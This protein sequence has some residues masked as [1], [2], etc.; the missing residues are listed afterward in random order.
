MAKRQDPIERFW[1]QCAYTDSTQDCWEW[2]GGHDSGGYGHF[3]VGG[4]SWIATRW[5]YTQFWGSE[6][7]GLVCHSC[8]NTRCC[9]P[10]H[11]FDGT[12]SDNMR[13]MFAKGRHP[14]RRGSSHYATN[15]SEA[16]VVEMRERAL[17]GESAESLAE[18]FGLHKM[19]VFSILRGDD[20][21]H[22]GG[23]LRQVT[24]KGTFKKRPSGKKPPFC[25]ETV[26]R[27]WAKVERAD[28]CWEWQGKKNPQGY[29][30]FKAP[31]Y[32]NGHRWLYAHL[33]GPI[34]TGQFVLH[35]C[36]NPGCVNP[37]HLELGDQ[38]ENMRQR[39]VRGRAN[40]PK[41][42]DV[43]TAL[44]TEAQVIEMRRRYYAGRATQKE[45]AQE[46]GLA[47]PSIG[48]VLRGETWAHVPLPQTDYPTRIKFSLE[49]AR[50]IRAKFATGA[51]TK[52]SLALEFGTTKTSI[53]RIISG[54][55]WPEEGQ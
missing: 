18:V 47:Y 22:A 2:Q 48:P 26:A 46:F 45:L 40:T 41:G 9:N 8:D 52:S 25:P 10:F 37:A 38:A 53:G 19:H 43:K 23:P 50:A 31:P 27:F 4:R 55:T 42:E 44:L 21:K 36:D 24:R 5:I 11:L 14:T 29:P 30:E 15:L 32:R 17:N 12:P 20:W 54:Q 7:A 39:S 51:V 3:K 49:T 6:P 1:R 35:K 34:P 28:G 16:K 33:F 13:D